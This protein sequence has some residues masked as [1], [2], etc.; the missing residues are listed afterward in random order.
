MAYIGLKVAMSHIALNAIND[1]RRME[2]LLHQQD[3][4]KVIH[5]NVY[6]H[7]PEFYNHDI[8]SNDPLH[9]SW[10]LLSHFLC[11]AAKV[12]VSIGTRALDENLARA[13]A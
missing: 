7:D 4:T 9:H 8:A 13:K 2:M 3:F 1:Y 10:N 12:A 6:L 11:N 5:M